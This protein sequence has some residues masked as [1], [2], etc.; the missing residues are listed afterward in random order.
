M[1]LSNY[2][3]LYLIY[4]TFNFQFP[5]DSEDDQCVTITSQTG[6]V[7][8]IFSCQEEITSLYIFNV[9][10]VDV[11]LKLGAEEIIGG[12]RANVSFYGNTRLR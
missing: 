12:L 10:A 7:L 3:L 1:D 6:D 11:H 5:S 9:T 8:V 2:A 4:C